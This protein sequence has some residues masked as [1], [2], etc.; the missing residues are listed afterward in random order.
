CARWPL[1]AAP[2]SEAFDIW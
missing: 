2:V 1:I